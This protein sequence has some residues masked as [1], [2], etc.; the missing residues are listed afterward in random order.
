MDIRYS[1]VVELIDSGKSFN[2]LRY[3]L[4]HKS[5]FDTKRMYG[6]AVKKDLETKTI[7]LN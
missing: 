5:I 4:G 2:E 1:R 6:D 7:P 3:I